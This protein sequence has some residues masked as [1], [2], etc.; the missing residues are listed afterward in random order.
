MDEMAATG[1]S[2]GV[3]MTPP[4]SSRG[5]L[6]VG[7]LVDSLMQPAWVV[8]AVRQII[9]DGIAEIVC[10]VV[11]EAGESPVPRKLPILQRAARWIENRDALAYAAYQRF[12]ARRYP[13]ARDPEAPEDLTPEIGEPL[14]IPV[15]PRM[16]KHCDYFPDDAVARLRAQE[17]DVL[18]RFGFRILKGAALSSARYGVWSFHHGDNT[19]NRGGPAGFWEVME[20]H[21]ATGAVLQRLTEQLDAGHVIA[22][23]YAATEMLSFRRNRAKFY[24]IAA[25]LL[26]QA[27]RRLRDEGPEQIEQPARWEA[28]SQ[29]LSVAPTSGE[30]VRLFLRLAKRLVERKWISVTEREQWIVAYRFTKGM[31]DSNDVPDG[32][33]YRFQELQPPKDRIWADPFPAA[34]EGRH[35]LFYEEKPYASHAHLCVAELDEKGRPGAHRIVLRQPYHLSYPHVFR[36]N[37]GWYMVPETY[38]QRRVELY[39]TDSFPDGWTLQATLL[40]NVEAVDPTIFEHDGRWWLSFASSVR[41]TYEASALHFY[42]APSPLGPWEPHRNNP[43]KVDVRSARPAGRVFHHEGRLYRPAQDGSPRYGSA[44]VMHELLELTPT[45][46]RE[47]EVA[48]ISPAWR[49]GLT[50]THTINAAGGLTAIDARQRRSRWRR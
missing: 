13:P 33:M 28:Y 14:V 26:P 12:D 27:L 15:M 45:S 47:E 21:R 44:I 36:W 23:S 30:I 35:F 25:Q 9:R 37:G 2:A 4:P 50:G 31:P 24:W 10:V 41:G 29:R 48:R 49:P 19:I 5:R 43:V 18:L 34:H 17:L 22:R 6:R 7:L 1:E 16:T 20:G 40:E 42:H 39:R 46:F 3:A 8:E 32:V 11:N 38:Q